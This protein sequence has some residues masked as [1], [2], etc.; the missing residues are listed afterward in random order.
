MPRVRSFP[1][2]ENSRARILILGSMPGVA[3]LRAGQ[4]YAHPQNQFWPI[5]CGLLG[6][7]EV[8]A[9]AAR[10][11]LLLAN[12]IALWDV[13]ESCVREGSLDSA[14]RDRTVEVNDFPGFFRTHPDVSRILFNGAKAEAAWRS[15]VL[16]ALGAAHA[17]LETLR[18]PSTSPAHAVMGL[19]QKRRAWKAGLALNV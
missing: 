3:S 10:V 9:Y 1:P 12:R 14:I 17:G 2:V 4:Y 15:K 5:V 11:R 13:L 7:S 8:P 19:A 16:P 6:L 18:L